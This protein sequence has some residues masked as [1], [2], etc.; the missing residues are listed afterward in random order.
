MDYQLNNKLMEKKRCNN[1]FHAYEGF[2]NL[3]DNSPAETPGAINICANCGEVCRFNEDLTLTPMTSDEIFD[4][5][6]DHPK[7]YT[8]IIHAVGVIANRI[9]MN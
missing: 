4:L 1:C 6:H 3:A 9:Q 2:I 5:V 8:T 7:V